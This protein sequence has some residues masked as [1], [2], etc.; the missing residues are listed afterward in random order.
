MLKLG[1]FDSKRKRLVGW[2][3]DWVFGRIAPFSTSTISRYNIYAAADAS[4]SDRSTKVGDVGLA[5]VSPYGN[6]EGSNVWVILG[7]DGKVVK[8]SLQVKKVVLVNIHSWLSPPRSLDQDLN[9][10][11]F[12]RTCFG[13]PLFVWPDG[14]S[15]F[16]GVSLS[17][18]FLWSNDSR[19]FTM[20]RCE[21]MGRVFFKLRCSPLSSISRAV[22][23]VRIVI[24]CAKS[25][26][27]KTRKVFPFFFNFTPPPPGSWPP[28]WLE[29]RKWMYLSTPT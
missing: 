22:K 1:W 21:Q 10:S 25:D 12:R 4:G 13:K 24:H 3:G 5:A 23:L 11:S 18:V 27:V 17:F 28:S 15:H 8:A 6:C 16:T 26:G 20:G 7:L 14:P 29:L 19:W 2:L 9:I